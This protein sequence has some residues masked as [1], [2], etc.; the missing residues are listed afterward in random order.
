MGIQLSLFMI[1]DRSEYHHPFLRCDWSTDFKGRVLLPLADRFQRIP[2]TINGR[3]RYNYP[4]VWSIGLPTQRCLLTTVGRPKFNGPVLRSL[5]YLKYATPL[6]DRGS[7]R[8]RRPGWPIRTQR[9][10]F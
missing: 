2:F 9:L 1:V 3:P 8:I 4:F 10:R 7:M 5:A 6:Y